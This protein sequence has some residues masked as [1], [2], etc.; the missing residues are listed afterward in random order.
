MHPN[1]GF[2]SGPFSEPSGSFPSLGSDVSQSNQI[3]NNPWMTIGDEQ[4]LPTTTEFKPKL[5]VLHSVS[6]LITLSE[7]P[8]ILR[9]KRT[10]Y[11]YL[12][13]QEKI[14]ISDLIV[15]S[16]DVSSREFAVKELSKLCETIDGLALIIWRVSGIPSMITFELVRINSMIDASKTHMSEATANYACNLINII[17]SFAMQSDIRDQLMESNI[18]NF[19]LSLVQIP[20]RL[21]SLEY[22]RIVTLGVLGTLAKS[23]N[24]IIIRFLVRHNVI[25]ACLKVMEIAPDI[26]KILA[27]FVLQKIIADDYGLC[28]ICHTFERFSQTAMI[29]GRIV[30]NLGK[31]PESR[32]LRHVIRCYFRLSENQRA[33]IALKSCLPQSLQNGTFHEYLSDDPLTLRLLASLLHNVEQAKVDDGSSEVGSRDKDVRDRDQKPTD[34]E[35]ASISSLIRGSSD[36]YCQFHGTDNRPRD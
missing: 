23:E 18:I 9:T 21:R 6:N 33:S 14:R 19:L 27:A 20:A 16:L 24:T 7:Q 28:F 2:H 35:M 34:L 36:P 25:E 32:L 4:T 15:D 1:F 5:N 22:L 13:Q 3:T 29:L 31:H 12:S 11:E 30:L 17:Q 26:S 8:N 10:Q